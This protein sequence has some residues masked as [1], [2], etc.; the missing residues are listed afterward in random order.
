[1]HWDIISS[2]CL[3]I[4]LATA[5][6]LRV[7]VPLLIVSVASHFGY[8]PLSSGFHWLSSSPAIVAFS[9]AAG[10]EIAGYCIPW[11]DHLLDT[12]ASPAAVMAGTVVAVALMTNVDPFYKWAL[13]IIA[14]GGMAGLMQGG[15]MV[16]RGTSTATTGGIANPVVSTGELAGAIGLSILTLLVPVFVVIA[17][18][19]VM[20]ISA[21]WLYR[22]WRRRKTAPGAM[23]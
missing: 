23:I 13:A 10:L 17:L 3:G 19:L 12:I 18:L 14:G 6:G 22:R 21:W 15:T 1:M 16:A 8:L 11:V 9:V 4:G 7:F 5:C 20:L 2:I